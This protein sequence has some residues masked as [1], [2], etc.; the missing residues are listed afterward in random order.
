MTSSFDVDGSTSAISSILRLKL[1]LHVT[2]RIK[3]WPY[4]FTL[5]GGGDTGSY[6]S[7]VGGFGEGE[8]FNL[9]AVAHK[10]ARWK[11]VANRKTLQLGKNV[12]W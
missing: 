1:T 9:N 6:L 7:C 12:W 4:L 3:I 11:G 10:I 8:F 5:G 2:S